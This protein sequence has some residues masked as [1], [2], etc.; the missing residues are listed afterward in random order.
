MKTQHMVFLW[1]LTLLM[2]INE[3]K[4]QNRSFY[5]YVNQ[6][7]TTEQNA[8]IQYY[9]YS[10]SRSSRNIRVVA[11]KVKNAKSFFMQH[12]RQPNHYQ[13]FPQDSIIKESI[14]AY[15]QMLTLPN[16]YYTSLDLGKLSAG[17]YM[18]E[19]IDK[20][21]IAQVP[22]F[23]TDW[24]IL[25]Q[26][27]GDNL[28]AYTVNKKTGKAIRNTK[29]VILREARIFEPRTYEGGIAYFNF[30][31]SKAAQQ[32][33]YQAPIFSWDDEGNVAVSQHYFNYYYG[34]Y[35][36]SGYKSYIVTDRS[37][38]RPKQIVKF[39]GTFRK[40]TEKGY[41]VLKDSIVCKVTDAQNKEVYK[42]LFSLDEYGNFSDSLELDE[43]ASLG[44]Y[45]IIA[46]PKSQNV[47]QNR[48][49]YQQKD[50]N[51]ATFLVEEYKKPEYEVFVNLDKSQYSIGDNIKANIKAKYFFGSPVTNAEVVYK[52]VRQEYHAPVRLR[53]AYSWWY[54]DYYT[55]YYGTNRQ[56]I[57]KTGTLKLNNNGECE[58]SVPTELTQPRNCTYTIIA[59]VTDASRRMISSSSSAMVTYSDFVV[60]AYGDKYYYTPKDK[61]TITANSS[62]YNGNPVSKELT[63]TL[64]RYNYKN[65]WLGKNKV[66]IAQ[67]TQVSSKE[68]GDAVFTFEPDSAGYYRIEITGTDNKKHSVSCTV[69]SYVL[70]ENSSYFA[71]W[72]QSK[73]SVQIMTDKKVYQYGEDIKAMIYI[74]KSL[75]ALVTL[76]N[77]FTGWYTAISFGNKKNNEEGVFREI[78]IPSQEFLTGKLTL[79]V[80]GIK[81]FVFYHQS[82]NISV[83]PSHKYLNVELI[84]DQNTYKP[85]TDATA[86][87]R[88][89]DHKGNPVPYSDV[90]LATID[91]AIFAMYP[92]KTT[93][94][95]KFFYGNISYLEPIIYQNYYQYQT[96]YSKAID[97]YGASIRTEK[98]GK[99]FLR[100]NYI[101]EGQNYKI[102]ENIHNIP[103]ARLCGYILDESGVPVSDA[104]ITIQNANF[105]TNEYG[106]YEIQG[107][108]GDVDAISFKVEKQGVKTKI[109]NLQ[110]HKHKTTQFNFV[111]GDNAKYIFSEKSPEKPYFGSNTNS[112]TVL[113]GT[114]KDVNGNPISYAAIVLR[115]NEK[116]LFNA[117]SNDKGYFEINNLVPDT[118]ELV[119]RYVGYKPVHKNNF[120]VRDKENKNI[121]IVLSSDNQNSQSSLAEQTLPTA[122]NRADELEISTKDN[123]K[124]FDAAGGKR[125][126]SP[127]KSTT[128]QK[129]SDDILGDVDGPNQK[130]G[131]DA[132]NTPLVEATIR[133]DFRDAIY[134]N[135]NIKTDKNGEAKVRIR[136]PDNL[137]TWRSTARVITKNTEVG[138]Q[139]VKITVRKNLLVRMETPRFIT[140]GDELLIATNIHNYLSTEKSVKVSLMADGVDVQ[141]TEQWIKVPANGEK[142]IDWKIFAPA[143]QK[144]KFT[145]KSLTDEESD[146]M[147]MDVPVLPYGLE[148]IQS[149]STEVSDTQPQQN[150]T[151]TIPQHTDIASASL[152]LTVEPS[153]TSALLNGIEN[154]IGYPYGCV[155][156]TMSRFLP[157]VIVS[158]TLEGLGNNEYTASVNK[159]ELA[160]M[161]QAGVKRLKELQHT[162]GGWGWWTNDATHPFMTAYVCNGLYLARKAGHPV[163]D[164]MYNGGRNAL[165]ELI[166]N[167]KSDD[168]ATH[169][170][171][172]MVALNCGMS[173]VWDKYKTMPIEKE[174]AYTLSLWL[175]AA[176]LAKDKAMQEKLL[177]MLIEKMQKTAQGHYWGG[178][179]FYYSWQDDQVET[180]ANAIKAIYMAQPSHEA[181]PMAI[182]WLMSK[183]EGDAWHNTRQTAMAIYALNSFIQQ[184]INSQ[185]T[186]T[187][188]HNTKVLH[189]QVI[190]KSNRNKKNPSIKVTDLKLGDNTINIRFEGKGMAM[191]SGKLTYFYNENPSNEHPKPN[192]QKTDNDKVFTVEREYYKLVKKVDGAG[193]LTYHKEKIDFKDLHSGEEILVKCK[194]S[195]KSAQDFVLIEDPIP[196]GCEFIR[197]T[198]GYIIPSEKEYDG[199]SNYWETYNYNYRNWNRWYT[200]REYR[201]SKLAIT[202]TKL[203]PGTYE[204]SYLLK[205]QIPGKYHVTPA[206]ASLMYYPE[207][208][209]YSDFN[210]IH[211]KE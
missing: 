86:T 36:T 73:R 173:E 85:A 112:T 132:P 18:V 20:G 141:G 7:F 21:Q 200:H 136:L 97:V 16:N 163:P 75:D 55:H 116:V 209:G 179:R 177:S 30:G 109:Q 98:L 117:T 188:S 2:P 1:V 72:Q 198:K 3:V 185:Y 168:P 103:N 89:T 13:H 94:I 54:H 181:L 123:A 50:E 113:K 176:S 107:I 100:A 131:E 159:E 65:W 42:K 80:G 143:I 41:E 9:D 144:V 142:R 148:M 124:S 69:T 22:L 90:T 33:Y 63:A 161:V 211:I 48:Y 196:A 194:V 119:V 164:E 122:V 190:D 34:G 134:W 6:V 68:T 152:Y 60:S 82:T 32:Y 43:K 206:I 167:K 160:K 182:R 27:V 150:L 153:L 133:S 184:E 99:N 183:R 52:V 47:Y 187:V 14:V 193:K 137:T 129:N 111:L 87:L 204:Y 169:A 4:A 199:V 151:F 101:D 88:V 76:R 138:Q 96:G 114:V 39:K 108:L 135:P 149:Q 208:R 91:E 104:V 31:G 95:R 38:Y 40:E 24:A 156:Q 53:Y 11:Y 71:W 120:V 74:P 195:T 67:K 128:L 23:V 29:A 26:K 61:M 162:D 166:F 66:K 127:R 79:S 102:F 139:A 172:M 155:E 121:N 210:I 57:V 15:N 105:Y 35:N 189:K 92:D 126:S 25:T 44:E 145:V 115:K 146:A 207:Y 17:L 46:H 175:Q 106:Y 19:V 170:Y 5:I 180:T 154:L 84:F 203:S 191:V 77:E 37:G 78:T 165:R 174:N 178:K 110:L 59:E 171:Q 56:E 147:T 205:A 51:V 58:F 158:N 192:M 10:Y 28:I 157:N 83:I 118:Y 49:Y 202:I 93:D 64:Y 12:L 125:E 130:Q 45:K 62:D 140:L 201:D 81:D 197:D 186:I 70:S 8:N